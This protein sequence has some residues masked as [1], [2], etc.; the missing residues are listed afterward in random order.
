MSDRA[1]LAQAYRAR[2]EAPRARLRLRRAVAPAT[3]PHTP[4]ALGR[5]RRLGAGSGRSVRD[6]WGAGGPR[7]D[8]RDMSP[9]GG[10]DRDPG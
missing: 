5:S 4:W 2:A 6:F 8:F 7:D 3:F 1:E 9:S 10:D